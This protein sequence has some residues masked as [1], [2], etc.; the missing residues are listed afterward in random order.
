MNH[1]REDR[2][3]TRSRKGTFHLKFF[4]LYSNENKFLHRIIESKRSENQCC[5]PHTKYRC[6]KKRFLVPC[7]GEPTFH[8][9]GTLALSNLTAHKNK[10]NTLS[11][12]CFICLFHFTFFVLLARSCYFDMQNIINYDYLLVFLYFAVAIF[13][14]IQIRIV[15]VPTQTQ[16]IL[17]F[18][19]NMKNCFVLFLLNLAATTIIYRYY[20]IWNQKSVFVNFPIILYVMFEKKETK[21]KNCFDIVPTI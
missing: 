1:S 3:H 18:S 17:L 5:R 19:N 20:S 21:Q 6:T 12:S 11:S 2:E 16:S 13:L 4:K 10:P 14:F 7:S 8:L 15:F 9:D